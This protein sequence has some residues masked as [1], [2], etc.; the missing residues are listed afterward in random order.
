MIKAELGS[1][2]PILSIS[3]NM[4]SISHSATFPALILKV[5]GLAENRPSVLKGDHLFARFSDKSDD[6]SYKGY[7]HAVEQEDVVLGFHQE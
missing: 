6:K 2:F 3:I 7:V 1:E 4:E 5:P